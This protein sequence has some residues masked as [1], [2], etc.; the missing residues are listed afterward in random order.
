[1]FRKLHLPTLPKPSLGWFTTTPRQPDPNAETIRL[2]ADGFQA[3]PNSPRHEKPVK[4]LFGAPDPSELGVMQPRR[5]RDDS[6]HASSDETTRSHLFFDEL[7]SIDPDT[8]ASITEKPRENHDRSSTMRDS[9]QRLDMQTNDRHAKRHARETESF[10]T[11][12]REVPVDRPVLQGLELKRAAAVLDPDH[13]LEL[14]P[15]FNHWLASAPCKKHPLRLKT[16]GHG[17]PFMSRSRFSAKDSVL[18]DHDADHDVPEQI[19]AYDLLYSLASRQSLDWPDAL[20]EALA[21]LKDY[22]EGLKPGVCF[23]AIKDQQLFKRVKDTQALRDLMKAV[24]K[25][26]RATP[27]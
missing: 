23:H 17:E 4:V 20:N 14:V 6:L 15:V 3:P 13:P 21:A 19:A 24:E 16:P 9:L 8:I 2:N 18:F 12:E 27:Q 10:V 22:L 7:V 11:L 25:A 5:F 26:L 1:M